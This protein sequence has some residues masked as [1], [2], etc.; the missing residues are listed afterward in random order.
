MNIKEIIEKTKGF[1]GEV[2][3]EGRRVAW[4]ERKELIDST[5]VVIVFILILAVIVLSCD[6][7]I[8]VLLDAIYKIFL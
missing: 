3:S 4:P 2:Y 5:M 1:L 6:K 7:V 8:K